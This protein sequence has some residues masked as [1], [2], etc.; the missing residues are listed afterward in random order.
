[1]THEEYH[2][3]LREVY[4]MAVEDAVIWLE[5]QLDRLKMEDGRPI[6]FCNKKDFIKAFKKAM[7]N[8]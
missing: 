2:D 4:K 5:G 1:M 7:S 6:T 8:E 3:I